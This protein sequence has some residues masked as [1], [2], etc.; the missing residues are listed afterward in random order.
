VGAGTKAGGPNYLVGLG[1][2]ASAPS[3]ATTAL[4]NPRV[5]TLLDAASTTLD[6]AGVDYLHRAARSDA[7]AWA[8]EFGQPRD[9]S[10]LSAERN[11]FRYVPHDVHVRLP[12]V[13]TTSE[14]VLSGEPLLR[15][16]RVLLASAMAGAAAHVSSALPLPEAVLRAATRSGSTFVVESNE[17]WL[18]SASRLQGARVRLVDG[19]SLAYATAT[20]SASAT[21]AALAFATNGRPDVAVYS[22]PVT[23]AGRVELLPFLSEQAVSITA[24]RFGTPHNLTDGMLNA[25]Y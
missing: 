20:T 16:V 3:S 22:N 12:G 23:E 9:M 4:A 17:Q 7:A 19:E 1:S 10:A 25:A 5:L 11:V 2:W 21:A 13:A 14:P 18:V 24:H 8:R 6:S 15:L